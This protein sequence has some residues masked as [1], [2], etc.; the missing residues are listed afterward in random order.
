MLEQKVASLIAELRTKCQFSNVNFSWV[1]KKFQKC[2][3]AQLWREKYCF[4]TVKL[5]LTTAA[6]SMSL[7]FKNKLLNQLLSHVKDKY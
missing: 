5:K 2:K 6:K 4:F 3:N 7:M 1:P